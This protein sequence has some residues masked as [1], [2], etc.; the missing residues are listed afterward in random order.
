MVPPGAAL[1]TRGVPAPAP[2]GPIRAP[3]RALTAATRRSRC[4]HHD[5]AEG[6]WVDHRMT[7][8][9][10]PG[11]VSGAERGL[12]GPRLGIRGPVCRGVLTRGPHQAHTSGGPRIP[13]L[14]GPVAPPGNAER[15]RPPPGVTLGRPRLPK[16]AERGCG[17]AAR[18]S[19]ARSRG[20]RRRGGPRRPLPHA[21]A[22]PAGAPGP[23]PRPPLVGPA[24][25]RRPWG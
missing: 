4:D 2:S 19:I 3:S 7:H 1:Q 13:G 21:R 9:A 15:G 17:G 8:R 16:F 20:G 24:P 14:A 25:D 10:S 12:A 23:R 5:Q 11:R 6:E 18:R 22:G